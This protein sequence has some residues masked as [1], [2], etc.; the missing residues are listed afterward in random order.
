MTFKK[1]TYFIAFLS[2]LSIWPNADLMA[3][4]KK[5]SRAQLEREKRRNLEKIAET[6]LA[7]ENTQEKKEA[8]VGKIKAIKEQISSQEEQI[9]LM[10]QDLELIDM[11]MQDI[12]GAKEV[13]ERKLDTLQREYAAMLYSAS[14]ISGKINKLS[15]LFSSSSFNEL[16]MRYKYLQQYTD[17]R[18]SQVAQ[19]I[20]V[21]A[22]L[23]ERQSNL[24]GKRSDKKRIISA[25][26]TE[27]QYLEQLKSRQ[28][29]MVTELSQKEKDLRKEIEATKKSVSK[30][31]ASI[32][33]VVSREMA[34]KNRE[35]ELKQDQAAKLAKNKAKQNTSKKVV[36]VSNDEDSALGRSFAASKS[37]LPWPVQRGFISD[38]FGVKEHPVLNGV[39]INNNG[40]DIQTSTNA[41]VRS[42]YAGEVKDVTEIPGL[43]KVV[44]I[45]H[46][47][48]FTVYANLK[49]IFLSIGQKVSAK[50]T[51]GTAGESGGAPE[52]NFQIWH[53]SEHLNPE[54]WLSPR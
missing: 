39:L 48:Y 32:E 10:E 38:R 16:I 53:N 54:G 45:Q 25:K 24:Q 20:K 47:E 49:Q 31:E 28:T 6:K 4:R 3:Q 50:E 18:K 23:R 7:L 51:I 40:I 17:N 42:V 19:I 15:F 37:R 26:L 29:E 13:L 43:G 2:I 36:K 44:L 5:K 41:T 35:L 30:L 33:A 11:E 34:R 21:V 27:A 12:I 46:G 14:K 1:I 52:I 9:G 22:L 8:T